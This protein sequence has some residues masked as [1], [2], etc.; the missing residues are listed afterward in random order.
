MKR[1][2]EGHYIMIKGSIQEEDI[3]IIN[4]YAP[5]I[6][7]LQ[8]VRQMLTSMKGEIN[9][10]KIIVGDLNTPLTA[11]ERSAK[12]KINNETQTLN[13]ILDQLDLI[14]IYRTFHTQK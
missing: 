2:K 12:Q 3:T 13:D 11:M 4:I 10:N 1:D 9:N 5:N 14:D 8:Y 6:G 7:A